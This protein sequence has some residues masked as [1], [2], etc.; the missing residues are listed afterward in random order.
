MTTNLD[1]TGSVT[2]TLRHDGVLVIWLNRPHVLNAL[3]T[4]ML[5]TIS[6]MITDHSTAGRAAAIIITGVGR[7]F[8]AGGDVRAVCALADDEFAPYLSSY[9]ALDRTIKDSPAPVIAALNGLT[10]GGGLEIACMADIRVAD[11]DATL[12]AGDIALGL[13]PTGG[14]TWK[15]P[16]YIG[17]GRARWM[18][19]TNAT[20][21]AVTAAQMGLVDVVAVTGTTLDR[22]LALAHD[23]GALP[24]EGLALTK[25]A[26]AQ[27]ESDTLE[28]CYDFE[29]QSNVELLRRNDT[30]ERLH[31]LFPAPS[32]RPV[33]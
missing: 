33:P 30:M 21:D 31:E 4:T 8:S 24:V 29:V 14:L 25:R 7:A 5:A 9:A 12:C 26:L 18:L 27:A 23:M 10:Y 28:S 20:V 15:L 3:T 13:V 17:F 2:A 6:Q 16:R 22:A 1:E 11:Q 19:L 32:G